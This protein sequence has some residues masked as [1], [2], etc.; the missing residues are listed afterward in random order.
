MNFITRLATTAVILGS[1]VL[2]AMP[3]E[4]RPNHFINHQSSDGT[5]ISAKPVGYNGVEILV[6]N[7]Y[8]STGFILT[9]NCSTGDFR[10]RSN[11]GYTEARMAGFVRDIC[12]M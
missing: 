2:S 7:E 10:W 5:Y 6:D 1:T 3:A 9:A 8:T 11:T 4:A 12:R